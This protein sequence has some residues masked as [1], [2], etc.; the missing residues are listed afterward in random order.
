MSCSEAA[1]VS[2]GLWMSV[3]SGRRW[4]NNGSPFLE[5]RDLSAA[6]WLSA[7]PIGARSLLLRC[8]IPR[9]RNFYA[10]WDKLAKL[11]PYPRTSATRPTSRAL[12]PALT[13][14][15]LGSGAASPRLVP[16]KHEVKEFFRRD[17]LV[18]GEVRPAP[19]KPMV[20]AATTSTL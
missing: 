10:P 2:T 6:I 4:N 20:T 15:L 13:L 3:P 18:V 1:A 14:L 11:R 19:V 5:V 12:L 7:W 8:A 17:E 9:T 16:E